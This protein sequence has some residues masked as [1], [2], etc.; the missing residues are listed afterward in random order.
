METDLVA[1]DDGTYGGHTVILHTGCK[2]YLATNIS[3]FSLSK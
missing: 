3:A 1:I 2:T